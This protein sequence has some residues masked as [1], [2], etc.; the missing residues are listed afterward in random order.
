M[1]KLILFAFIAILGTIN[2]QVT[3]KPGMQAGINLAKISNTN[4]GQ[5]T[6]FYIGVFGALKLS[7]FYTLQPEL[8][9]S[10]QGG[11]GIME[12]G[13]KE[14]YENGYYTQIPVEGNVDVSLQY[15]SEVT[16]NKFNINRNIY[17]LVG[18]FVDIIVKNKIKAQNTNPGFSNISID[19]D[20]DFG[21]VGGVGYSLPK[22][23]SFEAR[24]KKG[25]NNTILNNFGH[26]RNKSTNLVIQIGVTYTFGKK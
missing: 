10:R 2:A 9:Y 5:K 4:L 19:Q 24:V 23:I 12:T 14:V 22:G 20:I 3:F 25:I 16:M 6:D 15:I 18:P 17:L 21:I 8:T 26:L 1:K 11:K 7:K 13:F